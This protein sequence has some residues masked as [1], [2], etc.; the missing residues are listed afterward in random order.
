MVQLLSFLFKYSM[1]LKW[2]YNIFTGTAIRVTQY[3][4]LFEKSFCLLVV[5]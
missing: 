5:S 4:S 2:F 3:G 1:M